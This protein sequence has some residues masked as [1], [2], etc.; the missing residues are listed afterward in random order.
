MLKRVDRF[1]Y[2]G[3]TVTE[4]GKLEAEISHQMQSGWRN[5]KIAL[6]VLWGRKMNVRIKVKSIKH[7]KTFCVV[8]SGNLGVKSR[9]KK[10]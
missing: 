5:W 1:K 2:L 10:K 9:R 4:N 3:L 7:G 6:G 8:S